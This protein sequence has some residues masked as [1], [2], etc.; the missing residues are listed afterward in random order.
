MI[1]TLAT[2]IAECLIKLAVNH[3]LS[4]YGSAVTF[5]KLQ[6]VLETVKPLTPDANPSPTSLR[7]P[8]EPWLN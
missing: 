4:R 7:K 6:S 5:V 8:N 2:Y 1:T 3:Y